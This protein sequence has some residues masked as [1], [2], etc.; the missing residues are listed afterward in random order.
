MQSTAFG[1]WGVQPAGGA[2]RGHSACPVVAAGQRWRSWCALFLVGGFFQQC[3]PTRLLA[4]TACRTQ[5]K[6]S[7]YIKLGQQRH[8]FIHQSTHARA[9]DGARGLLKIS[10]F[11][12]VSECWEHFIGARFWISHFVR[13]MD[14]LSFPRRRELRG[15]SDKFLNKLASDN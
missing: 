2:I 14:I 11:H 5:G 12:R 13:S 3:H 4:C 10:T 9:S 6:A 8:Y 15:N 1:A 7:L